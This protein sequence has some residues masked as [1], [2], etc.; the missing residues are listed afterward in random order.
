MDMYE[1]NFFIHITGKIKSA[2]FV[3][4]IANP[5]SRGKTE[6]LHISIVLD[7]NSEI[8]L[9]LARELLEGF[10]NEFI[11]INEVY[12][13]FYIDFEGTEEGNEKRSE[14]KE[15]F[16]SFYRQRYNS[17]VA[18]HVKIIMDARKNYGKYKVDKAK[19]L[20]VYQ[21]AIKLIDAVELKIMTTSL[22]QEEQWAEPK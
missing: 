12:K 6:L 15:L 13:A 11:K 7:I 5:Y 18:G 8:D 1:E 17:E 9:N 16:N 19:I 22:P 20:A 2:N 3:F 14:V 4:E 21:S 10:V